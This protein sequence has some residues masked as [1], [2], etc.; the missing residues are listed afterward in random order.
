MLARALFGNGNCMFD[1][2]ENYTKTMVGFRMEFYISHTIC[3][4]FKSFVFPLFFGLLVDLFLW[5][6]VDES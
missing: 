4:R 3:L 6:Q 1:S 5:K 2:I